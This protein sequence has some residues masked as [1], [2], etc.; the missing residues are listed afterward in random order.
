MKDEKGDS[1][2]KVLPKA[3]PS[4]SSHAVVHAVSQT[5][6]A[7]LHLLAFPFAINHECWIPS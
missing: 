2:I 5:G 1:G 7:P 3:L 4:D 6:S